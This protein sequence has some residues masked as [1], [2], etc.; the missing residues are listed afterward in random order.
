M[1][2]DELPDSRGAMGREII[3]DN[4]DLL[5]LGKAGHDLFQKSNK[6]RTCV[7]RRGLAQHLAGFGVERGVERKGAVTVVL[8]TVSLGSSGR[9]GQHG[10]EPLQSLDGVLSVHAKDCT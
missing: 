2:I 1:T 5:A 7:T 3:C 8:K 4:V 9:E 10:I 6:F